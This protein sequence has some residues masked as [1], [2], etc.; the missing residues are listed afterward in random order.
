MGIYR[1]GKVYWARWVED[2]ER[3]RRSLNTTDRRKAEALFERLTSK[4]PPPPPTQTFREILK[5]WLKH[6]TEPPRL[7]RRLDQ[8]SPTPVA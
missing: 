5:L 7:L 4:A 3:Q 6:Q 1:R 8:L 2:G